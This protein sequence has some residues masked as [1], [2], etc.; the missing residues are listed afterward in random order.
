MYNVALTPI[1]IAWIIGS[2]IPIILLFLL[3][4]P[5]GKEVAGREFSLGFIAAL[6]GG[7]L[8]AAYLLIVV[9]LFYGLCSVSRYLLLAIL[10]FVLS[11]LVAAPLKDRA[12]PILHSVVMIVL[13]PLIGVVIFKLPRLIRSKK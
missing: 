4:A 5:F 1:I 12:S 2:L 11:V 6:V 3:W 10:V 13:C 8:G 9:R 7:I